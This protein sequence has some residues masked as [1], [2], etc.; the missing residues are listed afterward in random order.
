MRDDLHSDY[1]PVRYTQQVG[2]RLRRIRVQQG[3]SLLEVEARS[4]REVKAS[5]LGAYERGE[6]TLSVPRL[7]RLAILYGVP[8]DHLLP[9]ASGHSRTSQGMEPAG[10]IRLDLVALRQHQEPETQALRHY[11]ATLQ[12]RRG[13]FNGRVLTIRRDDVYVLAASLGQATAQFVGRLDD[14]SVLWDSN[15]G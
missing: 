3:L 9:L 4:D 2:E 6:R 8:T 5:V 10:S 13:D 14:L 7:Q 11:V 15:S 1:N 12:R